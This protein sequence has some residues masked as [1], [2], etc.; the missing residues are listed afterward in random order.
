MFSKRVALKGVKYSREFFTSLCSD[1]V[2]C[3]F[4]DIKIMLPHNYVKIESSIIATTELLNRDRNYPA[5]ILIAKSQEYQETLKVLF[6]NSNSKAVFADDTFPNGQSE[7]PQLYFQSP[8]PGRVYAVFEFFKEY[9]QT[10]SLKPFY[11]F[12]FLACISFIPL[13]FELNSLLSK[14]SLLLIRLGYTTNYSLDVLLLIVSFLGL[15]LF[16]AYPKGLWIKPKRELRLFYLI[17]MA[18]HGEYRD[19][20]L[21]TLIVT[22]LGTLLA[23]ILLKW[24]GVI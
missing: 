11:T 2:S 16:F 9:L 6:I 5:L 3:K 13:F 14:K 23:T 17:N 19:N 24:L 20:P 8:D 15:F 12:L 10:P 21:V 22:V 18:I 1:L 4:N 7:P